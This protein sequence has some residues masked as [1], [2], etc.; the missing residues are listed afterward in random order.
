M[1]K[2]ILHKIKFKYHAQSI[3]T[4][5]R[6]LSIISQFRVIFLLSKL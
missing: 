2:F 4:Y 3:L 1:I 6:K 5:I